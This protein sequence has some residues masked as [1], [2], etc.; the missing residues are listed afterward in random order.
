MVCPNPGPRLQVRVELALSGTH[1]QLFTLTQ[2]GLFAT[3]TN[4]GP[5]CREG[6]LFEGVAN[7]LTRGGKKIPLL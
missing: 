3:W 1:A 7:F 2:G 5:P 6:F 4:D